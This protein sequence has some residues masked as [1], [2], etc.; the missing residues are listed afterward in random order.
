MDGSD[1]FYLIFWPAL[2]ARV[3]KG[4]TDG[5]SYFSNKYQSI[6]S[7]ISGVGEYGLEFKAV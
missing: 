5:D 1:F 4:I 7:Q 3:A 6:I 2:H